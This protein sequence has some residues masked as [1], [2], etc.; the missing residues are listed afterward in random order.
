MGIVVLIACLL[1][2]AQYALKSGVRQGHYF[3]FAGVLVFF[4]VMRRELSYLPEVYVPADFLWLGMTY[5]QWEDGFLLLTYI[6]MLG[7]L[8]YSW[9]YLR[10]VLKGVPNYLYVIV[11]VLALLQ[12]MGEHA[13]GFSM[14]YGEMAEELIEVVIYSIALVY[15]WRLKIAHYEIQAKN[16]SSMQT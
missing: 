10:A 4:N 2:C 3:W 6:I 8:A 16:S 15:L 12:Y 13:I 1:R 11:A 5:N 9:R 14:Y 7:C